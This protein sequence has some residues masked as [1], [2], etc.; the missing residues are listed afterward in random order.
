MKKKFQYQEMVNATVETMNEMGEEGWEL[1]AATVAVS[2]GDA[3]Y[4]MFFK[5][6]IEGP[7]ILFPI[8]EME[9]IKKKV[10]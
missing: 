9:H 3:L 8:G 1:V 7:D 2:D 5:R 10:G 4:V 6:E